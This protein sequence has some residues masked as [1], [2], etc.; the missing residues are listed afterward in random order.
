[1]SRL[2][3]KHPRILAFG[4]LQ[5]FFTAPGQTFL[6]SLFVA[7]IFSELGVSASLFATSYCIATLLGALILNPIGWLLDKYAPRHILPFMS[8]AMA[9]GCFL[10]ASAHSLLMIFFAFFLLRL[11]GQGGFSLTASTVVSRGFHKNRAK[12]MGLITLGYPLSEL[13][14]P[15]IAMT[16][17]MI[18]GWRMTYIIFGMMLL[19]VALPIQ[20]FLASH[21]SVHR[22]HFLPDE[23]HV[24]PH[25]LSPLDITNHPKQASHATLKEV[26]RDFDFYCVISASCIPPMIVTGLLFHQ[27]T[28]FGYHQWPL[29]L[30][31]SG[32]TLYAFLKAVSAVLVGPS[33]DKHGPIPA[34]ILMIVLLGSATIIA[35]IGGPHWIVYLY[36]GLVGIA[37]GL[38]SPVINVIWP[39]M[40]GTKHLGAIKG[41]GATFRNGLTALG[42]M[43]IAIAIDLQ[44]PIDL[45]LTITGIVICMMAVIP[46]WIAKRNPLIH[47][48]GNPKPIEE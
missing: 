22:G 13:I 15:G 28:L 38:G 46:L 14:F 37:L 44:F 4:V 1:M 34:F 39:N 47:G 48:K 5:L 36:L 18:Y 7:P 24:D 17:L 12:A 6:I 8:L 9:S 29:A 43:P 11:I 40:Y 3:I 25:T 32:L 35:G 2:L 30:A 42:P 10:L 21:D 20:Y 41:Y 45:V 23:L 33:V 26:V 27:S 16:L 19:A 31:V